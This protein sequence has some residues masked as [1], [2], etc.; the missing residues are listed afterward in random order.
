MTTTR[1]STRLPL[2][3]SLACGLAVANVYYSQPLLEIIGSEFGMSVATVGIVGTVTQVGYGLGLLLIV[4]LGDLLD[5][6]RLVVRQT[7]LSAVALGAVV[8][9][10]TG[11]VL[12]AS[13]AAVG[14][15]AVV[16]QVLV[17]YA[18]GLANPG[19]RGRDVG[20]VTSGIIVGIL[21]ARTVSGTLADLAG[22]RSVYVVSAAAALAMA[23]L[24]HVALPRTAEPRAQIPYRRLIG[25]VFRLFVEVP[26]LRVRAVLAAL[27][28]AAFVVLYTPMVLPLSAP[29]YS[30]STTQVGLFGLAGALGAL[31]ASHAGRLTDRGRGQRTT[32]IGLT[33]ML[34]SWLAV[35]F[36]PLSLWG[37]VV[38]VLAIDFGLQSVHVA[39]Q[40]L[41]YRVR[42]E[43]QSRLTAGYMIFYSVGS[44]AGAIAST[45]V[46][47]HA[48]WTGVCVLGAA[49]S[50]AALV[51]W[52]VTRNHSQKES[53]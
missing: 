33:I 20:I 32:G 16:T 47:A 41:I 18:A 43:A 35:A 30:L 49:I 9:A 42:P 39:N 17:A 19:D 21:L 51:F 29:P 27:I 50:L 5:R 1:A 45:T 14:A 52:A 34:G 22:W 46:Y 37:L 15:L 48:G 8:L 38:G 6:R 40:S 23:G 11:A 44:A 2:L 4:P 13:M 28:F 24:L 12:L 3:F 26:M 7:L 10:P 31:G 25:S 53:P 36:L